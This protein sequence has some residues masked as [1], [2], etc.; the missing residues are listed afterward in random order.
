MSQKQHFWEEQARRELGHTDVSSFL[1]RFVVLGF[2]AVIGLLPLVQSL[3]DWRRD[4]ELPSERLD[5]V[6]NIGRAFGQSSGI[7]VG[8]EEGFFNRG[9]LGEIFARN[10]N[11][12]RAIQSLEDWFEEQSILRRTAVWPSQEFLYQILSW[13]GEGV[14]SGRNGWLFLRDDMDYLL[15]PADAVGFEEAE[16]SILHFARW[17]RSE[18]IELVL[19]PV[20]VKPSLEGRH[21]RGG[22][23]FPTQG[24]FHPRYNDWAAALVAEGVH[25]F[26]TVPSL[27]SVSGDPYLKTD[28]HW[29]PTSM[30]RVAADLAVYISD[31]FSFRGDSVSL[32]TRFQ[33]VSHLGDLVDMIRPDQPIRALAPERVTVRGIEGASRRVEQPEIVVIGDS[34]TNI[35]ELSAMGWGE[36]GGFGS[37][38]LYELSRMG[39]RRE[40]ISDDAGIGVQVFAQNGDGAYA[41]RLRFL[42]AWQRNSDR[43]ANTKVL[44]WQ[45]SRRELT[46]GDWRRLPDNG[47]VS[48]AHESNNL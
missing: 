43:F 22:E 27:Q 35:F 11:A 37:Q 17:L 28:S 21:L 42:S 2:L 38:I 30:Q 32:Q 29:T 8:E 1:A 33:N 34:F 20:P 3:M 40:A 6:L 26:D 19:V 45:F 36:R 25:V 9:W 39:F 10:N 48:S 23:K 44:V 41:S 16:K 18:G 13:A 14:V 31:N 5:K 24:L 4:S 47:S 7:S 15:A 12:L 46:Q